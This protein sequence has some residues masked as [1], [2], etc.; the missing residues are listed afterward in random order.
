MRRHCSPRIIVPR[1]MIFICCVF[2]LKTRTKGI[3]CVSAF[4]EPFPPLSLL[5]Q[6]QR[7]LFTA[8][9]TLYLLLFDGGHC[10][11]KWSAVSRMLGTAIQNPPCRVSIVLP[12][13]CLINSLRVP[14]YVFR[15][16]LSARFNTLLSLLLLL[17]CLLMIR[18]LCGLPSWPW[19]S[20]GLL[21]FAASLCPLVR[22]PALA[23]PL[24][25]GAF[26]LKQFL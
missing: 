1:K 26:Q 18:M 21:A 19:P 13:S 25:P 7:C 20:L 23:H 11:A 12:I 16:G 14:P 22:E 17:S 2:W 15:V 24:S 6:P 5:H 8:R 3:D 9:T 10:N 4:C